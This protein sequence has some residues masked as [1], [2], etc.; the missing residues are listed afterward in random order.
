MTNAKELSEYVMNQLQ[1]LDEVRCIPMMGAIF[2][3]TEKEYS[4]GFTQAGLW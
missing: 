4:A 3:T 1:N 2:S